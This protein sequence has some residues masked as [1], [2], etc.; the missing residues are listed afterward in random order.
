MRDVPPN[1]TDYLATRASFRLEVPEVY[2]YARDVVD[3]RAGSGPDRLAL[4][5]V[6]PDGG[7]ARRF[8]FADLAASSDR[9]ARFLAGLGVAKGDRVFVMLPRVPDWYDVVLGCIKL[10]A[11]PMPATTLLTPRDIA[12]RVNSAE[13]SV[14][15]V[16][17]EGTTKVNQVAG[18]CPSLTTRVFLAGGGYGGLP[19]E[20]SVEA[21]GWVSWADGL[22]AAGEGPP[23]AE[24]T[25]S[26]DPMLLYFTSGTVA[27]P[28]MVLHTQASLGIGHQITARFWQD[29]KPDD[30]HWTVSDFG[31]AKA[32]WGKLFGQWALGAANFLWDVRGK[33]DLDLML[34]LLGEHGITTF[35][36][37][38]TIYRALVLLDL[39]GYDWS[40]LR[41]CVSAGE[42]LN[43][44]VI[45]VWREATGLT[46]YDGYGQTE[47]VNLVA[48]FRCLEVRPGSMGKP[49]PG[50]DVVVIDD[51]GQVLGPGQEGHVA[52]RVRPERPVGLFSGYWRDPEATAAAFRGD[53]YDTGDRAYVD[54]DGYFWFV[55]RD[56][57]VITS[58]A[59]RIGPFEVE[60]ALVEHPAVAEAAVVGK[61]DPQRGQLVKAFVVLAP[62]YD[63]TPELVGELQEHCRTVTAPYKYPREI[64][65]TTELPK[66]ISGKIRRVELRERELDRG[67]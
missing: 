40:R 10:G 43:P 6:G 22:A 64:E 55:A 65:F 18:D 51:Q 21:G 58:A 66:T 57:D 32:A 44:E 45:K 13:A 29:L 9:A 56:D 1:M 30:L 46:I 53:F 17:A 41:H 47:T 50:F 15:V 62:G 63:G 34:R 31:W 39:A 4:L 7:D 27:Y 37:P 36:A 14:V 20:G 54:E 24:P 35:C 11:I 16:D 67:G 42:P 59:Y 28:K 38:P 61:P 12:Y 19:D 48:N 8:S 52:V 3:A 23:E 25:R 49:T 2:N 26:D 5:A 33:P 60:S